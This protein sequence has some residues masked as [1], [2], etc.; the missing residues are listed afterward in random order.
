MAD[1]YQKWTARGPGAVLARRLGLPRPEPLRRHRPGRPLLTGPA[2][3]GGAP[4]GR[5]GDR[6]RA[7]LD[8]CGVPI[9]EPGPEPGTEE[10]RPAALVFDATGITGS[11]QLRALHA[12]FHPLIR[13]L[14]PCGRVIVLGTPPE[15][16]A[17]PA[18]ATA[19]RALEGF[20]R[21]VGKE[22]RRGGTAQLLLVA[23][24][25]EEACES[26]LRF[27]LSARSAYVSGQ[28]LRVDGDGDGLRPADWERPL[29]GRTA[30]VTG[31]SRGIGA[32]IA[33]TLHRDGARVI[34]L[35]LAGQRTAL[36]AV[37]AAS[38]GLAPLEMDIA[39]EDAPGELA[40]AV[41]ERAPGGVDIVVHNAGITRDKTLGRMDAGRWDS[42]LTVNLRAVERIDD[43]LL[44]GDGHGV[45]LRDGGRIVCTSS[46]AGIA[47]NAGQTNYATGKAGLIG[48]VRSL[49]PVAAERG[50]TVNAVAPGFIETGMT[51]AVPLLIREAGRRMNSLRQ[52]GL[53]VDVAETVAYFASPGSGAV[54]G[55]V[56]RVCGQSLLGA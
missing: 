2:V 31:A 35:D 54:T 43:H 4:G 18:E 26:T 47:G 25:A 41:R 42:V 55:Q 8:A 53:P 22:L 34:C 5:L 13:T 46:I 20:V 3:L 11:G 27:L 49:A 48:H 38:G 51:A 52:G 24:G 16:A 45:V 6:V 39:A 17:G 30:L 50:I 44:A 1:R 10:P 21:S 7:L 33:G 29:A 15:R 19:Q 56:L 37:A 28:V 9:R 12:F 40:R 23:P 36:A 14:A 32:A